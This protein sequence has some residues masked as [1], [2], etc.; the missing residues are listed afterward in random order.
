MKGW[1]VLHIVLM[2]NAL[3]VAFYE[4]EDIL[5]TFSVLISFLW[6]MPCITFCNQGEV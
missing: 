4:S 6:L 2:L 1:A 5:V 3:C